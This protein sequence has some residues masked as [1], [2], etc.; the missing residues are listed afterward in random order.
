M[1]YRLQPRQPLPLQGTIRA[2]W[3]QEISRRKPDAQ[4]P[5]RACDRAAVVESAIA[6]RPWGQLRTANELKK[7]GFS[8]SAAGSVACG[9]ATILRPSSN[10]SRPLEA[11]SAQEGLVLSDLQLGARENLPSRGMLPRPGWLFNSRTD[12]YLLTNQQPL[13]QTG[14]SGQIHRRSIHASG[15]SRGSATPGFSICR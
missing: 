13:V 4:E 1:A 7:H 11:T 5:G 14:N 15:G 2:G 9:S 8:V 3:L 6:G 10:G 12:L